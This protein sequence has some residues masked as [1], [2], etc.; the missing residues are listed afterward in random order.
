MIGAII[1]DLDET[2]FDRTKSVTHFLRDQY[3]RFDAI[4]DWVSEEEYLDCFLTLDNHRYTKKGI[5][6]PQP[7]PEIFLRAAR[8]LDVPATECVYI[9]DNPSADIVGAQQAGMKTIWF[10]NHLECPD[11]LAGKPDRTITTFEELFTVDLSKLQ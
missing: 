11:G 1:F 5:V 8:Q 3:R 4:C 2:L 9:G 7:D 10:R 6:F